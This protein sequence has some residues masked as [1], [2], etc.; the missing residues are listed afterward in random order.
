MQAPT[1]VPQTDGSSTANNVTTTAGD[2]APSADAQQN[3]EG[4]KRKKK[5]E[6]TAQEKANH[7][8]FMR[9]TRH[10]QSHWIASMVVRAYIANVVHPRVLDK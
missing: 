6:K 10:I 4:P 5:R 3:A 1:A 9:F 2:T 7:A 8:R